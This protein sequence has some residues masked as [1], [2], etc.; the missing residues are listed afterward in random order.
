M[1]WKKGKSAQLSFILYNNTN[2]I[3]PALLKTFAID[4]II[5]KIF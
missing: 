2:A 1:N 3:K 4:E 5:T